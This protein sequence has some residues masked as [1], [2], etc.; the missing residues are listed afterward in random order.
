MGGLTNF[1]NGISSFGVP[2]LGGFGG[3][4]WNGP[5][6]FVNESI[7]NDGNAGN[8]KAPLKTLDAALLRESNATKGVGGRNAVVY[9]WGTQHR[10]STLAW[11]LGSTHLIGIDAPMRR[12]K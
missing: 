10:S 2:V 7:G 4:P 6:Y 5:Y 9:F 8:A 1:P 11:N 3:I 12:G